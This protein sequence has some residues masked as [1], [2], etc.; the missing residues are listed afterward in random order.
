M[1]YLKVADIGKH[2]ACE[3][4]IRCLNSQTTFDN[5]TWTVHDDAGTVDAS[6]Q[7]IQISAHDTRV[8]LTV[9]HGEL[10]GSADGAVTVATLAGQCIVSCQVHAHRPVRLRL[11]AGAYVA[12]FR[13]G[14]RAEWRTL[15]V[16]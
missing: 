14:G 6:R 12:S 1:Q 4:T 9:R 2:E 13:H 7:G 11:P 16:Q 15:L 10:E 8:S 5:I 3:L